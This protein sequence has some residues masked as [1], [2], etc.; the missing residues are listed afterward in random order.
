VAK[1]GA[2]TNSIQ[3]SIS[4]ADVIKREPPGADGTGGRGYNAFIQYVTEPAPCL[5]TV[6]Q[7][8]NIYIYRKTAKLN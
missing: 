3:R 5:R 7:F 1:A 2:D 8:G 6:C 4:G